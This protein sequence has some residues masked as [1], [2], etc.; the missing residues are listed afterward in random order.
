MKY[1][2]YLCFLL[3]LFVSCKDTRKTEMETTI[4][5]QEHSTVLQVLDVASFK[6][7]QVTGVSVSD[8]GRI[9]VNF[10]RW[11]KGVLH[12]VVEIT[13]DKQKNSYPNTDW[14]SWNIG[15]P[16]VANKFVGVQSVVAFEDELYVL[17]TRS[18]LFQNVLDAPRV[19]VFNLKEDTLVKTY[20]LS[21]NSYHPDS[22]INDLRVDKKKNQIYFTDSGHAGL[23]ILDMETG[24]SKRVLDNHKSTSAEMAHLTFGD[25]KWER[26][27]HSDGI[28]LDTKNNTLYYHALTG[29]SLFAI[30]TDAFQN[31][32]IKKMESEVKF[33]A[34]TAAPDGMI[35]DENG[36]LY[37]ADLENNK[38]QFRKPDGSIHTL[39]EGEAI[40]WADTFSIY[41]NHLY[42][43]NS[44]INE[45]SGDISDML[46]TL[47][48]VPLPFT[49]G[50]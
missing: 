10:P 1:I 30:P 27:I 12:S 18:P 19:F 48:K 44:R 34:K 35:F 33:V 31:E 25:K 5:T 45:V 15:Q 50:K 13:S 49:V 8:T 39:A 42:F 2:Y 26:A 9:F 21:E 24:I 38:I 7:Q 23:V 4:D 47:K 11:R 32:D 22:Y 36:N 17:D 43:T 29:Y 20:V 3:I 46:F 41:N 28:A 6:G 14:N 16:V 40:Q 37:Y